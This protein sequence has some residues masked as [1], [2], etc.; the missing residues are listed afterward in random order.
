MS[1][2]LGV[3]RPE[4]ASYMLRAGLVEPD[5]D[6]LV[7]DVEDLRTSRAFTRYTTQEAVRT[8]TIGRG[9]GRLAEKAGFRVEAVVATTPV[10][11]DFAEADHTGTG[12][13]HAAGHRRGLR[14][15]GQGPTLVR[16]PR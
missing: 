1:T 2:T 8:A 6:T 4:Q 16:R 10:F 15:P 13:Q 11:R 14:R 7:V 12:P 9:L 5:W 3:T